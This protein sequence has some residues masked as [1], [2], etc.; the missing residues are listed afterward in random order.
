MSLDQYLQQIKNFRPLTTSNQRSRRRNILGT[1]GDSVDNVAK[2]LSKEKRESISRRPRKRKTKVVHTALN[3]V[4]L[5]IRGQNDNKAKSFRELFMRSPGALEGAVSL[6]RD[7]DDRM[8]W[9]KGCD[10]LLNLAND[11][12]YRGE[13]R[14]CLEPVLKILLDIQQQNNTKKFSADS[15]ALRFVENRNGIESSQ[16]VREAPV[17]STYKS[18]ATSTA[19]AELHAEMLPH[20]TIGFLRAMALDEASARIMTG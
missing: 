15:S 14:C 17:L 3:V 4:R 6:I 19:A 1:G 10:L 16:R 13:L 8:L 18:P 12:A 2:S 20:A 5:K 7:G 11:P 9:T